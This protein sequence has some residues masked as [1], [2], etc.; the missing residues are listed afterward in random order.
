M[1]FFFTGHPVMSYGFKCHS[2]I[3]FHCKQ[4]KKFPSLFPA[5]SIEIWCSAAHQ[6]KTRIVP[7]PKSYAVVNVKET[8]KCLQYSW[9]ECLQA[10]LSSRNAD[11]GSTDIC[12]IFSEMTKDLIKKTAK[13]KKKNECHHQHSSFLFFL[14]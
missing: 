7:F 11:R 12:H 9:D 13:K 6:V 10:Y 4:R 8:L 3:S 14:L 1:A 5:H 2:I